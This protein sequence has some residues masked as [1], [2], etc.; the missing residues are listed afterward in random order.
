MDLL[1]LGTG[2]GLPSKT[3]NVTAIALTL[4]QERG[5]FWLFDCG[6][7]TQHQIMRSPLSLAKLE[8]VFI[9]HLHGDHI[10]GLPGVLSSR[11]FS[12]LDRPLDMY[13]P[14]GLRAFVEAALAASQTHLTYPLRIHE[15][16]PASGVAEGTAPD[17]T[18]PAEPTVVCAD[19]QFTVICLPL[20]HGIPSYGYRIV[21]HDAPGTL[22]VAALTRIG[23]PAGPIYGQLKRGDAVTLPDGRVLRPDAFVGAPKPGRVIAILGDTRPCDHV[24]TLAHHADVL[25]HEATFGEREAAL[26]PSYGHSTAQDAA[27]AAKS[28]NARALILTHISARYDDR[29]ADTLAAEARAIFPNTRLANDFTHITIPR[30]PA[31]PDL[32][33][34]GPHA[35][36]GPPHA[37]APP[38]SGECQAADPNN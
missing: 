18:G 4:F 3:R 6:E 5:T 2:A 36:P 13:G 37:L 27:R 22:D 31:E 21:E 33:Q 1:F 26:A 10:F 25:V 28:A 29:D 34:P 19:H 32:P 7:A 17:G 35:E 11:S 16:P 30:R 12:G 23:V 38:S 14:T 15:I 20:H 8:K 24:V 9:T